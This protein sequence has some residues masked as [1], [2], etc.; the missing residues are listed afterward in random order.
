MTFVCGCCAG[1]LCGG[2]DGEGG[3]FF[4]AIASGCIRLI[5]IIFGI[6]LLSSSSTLS[7]AISENFEKVTE[8]TYHEG[9]FEKCADEYSQINVDNLYNKLSFSSE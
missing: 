9:M 5:S 6:I 1:V 4:I 8:L 2:G 7:W 3:F